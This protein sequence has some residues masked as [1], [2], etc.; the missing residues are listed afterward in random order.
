MAFVTRA[1]VQDYRTLVEAHQKANRYHTKVSTDRH[2]IFLSH[3]HRDKELV[4]QFVTLLGEHAQYVYI[5]W[6]DG[7]IP[8]NCT[9]ATALYVKKKINECHKLVLLATENACNSRWCPW[10]LG[11]GD[12]AN[13]MSNV[14]VFPV[15]EPN[16][17][18]PG[19]EYIGIYSYVEKDFLG[20]L[21]VVDPGT[22]T[23]VAL[24]T[25]LTRPN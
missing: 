9:P 24:G 8:E 11:V 12:E 1:E 4:E 22:N 18:W 3:S 10:E 19:N 13:G 20:N 17:T 15:V 5:D 25:W 2:Y 21:Y 7:T 16:R 6:A 23:R 14:L